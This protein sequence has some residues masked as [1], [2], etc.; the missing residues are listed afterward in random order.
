MPPI[1][2]ISSQKGGVG[3]T[4]TCINLGAALADL[5]NR[6]LLID[7]D[8][9]G[10][11]AEGFGIA[12]LSINHEMSDVLSGSMG[13][14]TIIQ[15]M[16]PRLFL[17]PSNVHLAHMEAL[18]ITQM[19]REDRLKN[20][21]VS[22]ADT[23]DYIL[24]DCPPSL[25]VLTVNALSAAN[26]VLIPMLT[27]FYALVGVSLILDTIKRMQRE[28]NPC[29]EI[30]GIVPTRLDNTRHSKDVVEMVRKELP[31]VRLFTSIPEAVAVRNATAAAQ[32]VTEYDPSSPAAIAYQTLAQE[33][34]A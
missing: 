21:L 23:Y 34:R 4:T 24:I 29:L 13:I 6:V 25:G 27:E 20:A 33:L 17:A 28:L 3:K 31:N 9:Q 15:E 19:R 18:L 12:A 22:V 1:I 30:L 5:G 7:L 26:K 14:E 8:P 11:M 16:R 2:A 32:T 10:H